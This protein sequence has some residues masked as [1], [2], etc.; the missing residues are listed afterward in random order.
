MSTSRI[1]SESVPN[2]TACEVWD[3]SHGELVQNSVKLRKRRKLIDWDSIYE[4]FKRVYID[5]GKSLPETMQILKKQYD[6]K[7]S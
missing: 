4:P 1:D 3:M 5:E 6:F 2:N 7:P